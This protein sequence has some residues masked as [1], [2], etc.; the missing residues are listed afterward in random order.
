MSTGPVSLFVDSWVHFIREN[1]EVICKRRLKVK[2]QITL[3]F[4]VCACERLIFQ[5]TQSFFLHRALVIGGLV[6]CD[7]HVST[8]VSSVLI[9]GDQRPTNIT[10]FNQ[11][12]TN[13]SISWRNR[14]EKGHLTLGWMIG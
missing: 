4:H 7:V 9:G 8:Q 12:M 2:S 3:V 1:S 6:S 14:M 10:S 13:E 11:T 5:S